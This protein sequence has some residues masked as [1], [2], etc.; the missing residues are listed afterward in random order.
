[1]MQSKTG[2][3][4]L[5][6]GTRPEGI[7]MIPVYWELK[8]ARLPVVLCAASQH[9]QLLDDVFKVFN[10]KP[11]Y[12]LQVM[13]P[14]Q[15]LHYITHAILQKTKD[16]FSQLKPSLVLV[17]GDTT[18]ALASGLAE[19]YAH[20][21]VGHVEAGLRTEDV[22]T[23]YPEE[24]NR[25]LLTTLAQLHF[26]PT[27]NA[28]HNLL[29]AGVEPARICKTGNTGIDALRIMQERIKAGASVLRAD[30]QSTLD[31]C[32]AEGK[33]L[34]LLTLHRREATH[35][36]NAL[37]QSIKQW[38]AVHEE[39]VC[40]YP[41]HPNPLVLKA[42][43]ET[44]LAELPNVLLCEPCS[45]QDMVAL[46]NAAEI[47]VTDSGGIQEEA[48]SL[49]KKVLV[50][51]STT[52]RL[53]GINA[54]AAR[55][56]GTD[57]HLLYAELEA[58]LSAPL[59]N[60][61]HLYGDG[62]AARRIVRMIERFLAESKHS[63]VPAISCSEIFESPESQAKKVVVLGLGYI[64]LP[65]AIV[66]AEHGFQVIGVDIDKDRVNA[67]HNGDPVI[68]EPEIFERL[69]PVIATEALQV[70]TDMQPG[71]YFII[72]VPTPV[73]ADKKADLAYVH[74]A[75]AMISSVIQPGAV[76]IV[77]STVPVGTCARIATLIEERSTLRVG[78]DFF[79]AY[80]P[81]RVLPGNIFHELVNN[82]R[83]IGGVTDVCGKQAEQ[84]YASFVRAPIHITTCATAEMVKLVEN[85][86]RDV[87][88]AFAH[89]VA[90]IADA[91]GVNPYEVIDLANK[92]P[93]VKILSPSCGVG[94]HCIAVD[95]WFLIE[96][97]PEQSHLLR[98]ARTANDAMPS[99]V[100]ERI[101]NAVK[102]WQYHNERDCRVT[103]FGLTYK[104]NVDDTR[105]SPALEVAHKLAAVEHIKITVVEPHLLREKLK[106]PDQVELVSISQGV[107]SADIAIFLVA[108]TRF[109][110]IDYKLLRKKIVLDFCGILGGAKW[111]VQEN[112]VEWSVQSTEQTKII[113]HKPDLTNQGALP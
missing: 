56:V 78:R 39:L 1:M 107:E 9:A 70:A 47:V 105:E 19:F 32:S 41:Y 87:Q 21:P 102:A 36:L 75:V 82:A 53:E 88:L 64:G 5:I 23:P 93:R 55:L 44:K 42:V 6:V 16:L 10:V 73:T 3:I 38:L 112:N 31:A 80:C 92:H 17:Q 46:L 77:E 40:V 37:L 50:V 100:F 58:S 99:F 33:R 106:I 63:Y 86:S 2:P 4:L 110:A 109:A 49:G 51:R 18:T 108:H 113:N 62:Y 71:D 35:H 61:S 27:E 28:V 25:R 59:K 97:F 15:D 74:D 54:Q 13:R 45:Y 111:N 96:T 22:Y 48:A 68:Q 91:A 57:P 14:G 20:I 95:P 11:D 43:Q 30:I 7:K 29:L 90:T 79:V 94:G 60:P 12:N 98:A 101:L 83:V 52:E 26:A 84:L 8:A 89:Q 66:A 24:M 103:L 81:E 34:V 72:A 65:T 67:I 76:I 69:Q 104:P 85:S